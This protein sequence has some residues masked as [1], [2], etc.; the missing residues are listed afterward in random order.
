MTPTCVWTESFLSSQTVKFYCSDA[1]STHWGKKTIT[2]LNTLGLATLFCLWVDSHAVG[3]LGNNRGWMCTWTALAYYRCCRVEQRFMCFFAYKSCLSHIPWLH[4]LFPCGIPHYACE[5]AGQSG[6][7]ES[8]NYQEFQ[9]Q[10]LE[11]KSHLTVAILDF[12]YGSFYWISNTDHI[13]E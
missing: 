7:Q 5:W 10:K 3:I 12:S 8:N 13:Q 1:S 6:G 9:N 4:D 11:N 2:C